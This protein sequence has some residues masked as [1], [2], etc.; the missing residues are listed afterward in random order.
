ME[1]PAP[2]AADQLEIIQM[3]TA[4]MPMGDDVQMDELQRW[5]ELGKMHG[6]MIEQWCQLAA[7]QVSCCSPPCEDND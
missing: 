5:A 1:V 4:K 2:D 6:A 3:Y 7:L